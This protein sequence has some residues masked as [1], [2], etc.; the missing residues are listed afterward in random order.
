MVGHEE[1]QF[2]CY[3]C[4]RSMPVSEAA[5][6]GRWDHHQVAKATAP[7]APE[8]F[9]VLEYGSNTKSPF[10]WRSDGSVFGC[11]TNRLILDSFLSGNYEKGK[12]YALDPIKVVGESQGFLCVADFTGPAYVDPKQDPWPADA[13]LVDTIAS[14]PPRYY[15]AS[16]V[17]HEGGSSDSK[18]NAYVAKNVAAMKLVKGRRYDISMSPA[19]ERDGSGWLCVRD[20]VGPEYREPE[21]S[22]SEP[23]FKAGWLEKAMAGV[24]QVTIGGAVYEFASAEAT[25]GSHPETALGFYE[26]GKLTMKPASTP[27]T[28]EPDMLPPHIAKARGR[29]FVVPTDI[30]DSWIPDADDETMSGR[31]R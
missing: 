10:G 19:C 23:M 27:V 29:T 16:M 3:Q 12:R 31:L 30:D 4:A 8:P 18:T 24:D 15:D 7:E 11:A 26:D 22:K 2:Y 25:R 28:R 13:V 1:F 17:H 5:D 9:V 20:Y 21:K 6:H 14:C